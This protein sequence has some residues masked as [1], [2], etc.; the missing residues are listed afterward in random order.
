MRPGTACH[1]G[2]RLRDLSKAT[3]PAAATQ[4]SERD[5]KL[6]RIVLVTATL[7]LGGC[8]GSTEMP[9]APSPPVASTAPPA[10]LPAGDSVLADAT[11]SGTVYEIAID[12]AS[13]HVGIE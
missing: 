5:M 3:Q 12:S 11:L 2:Q 13:R 8:G 10:A 4:E 1:S 6:V 9:S 7:G